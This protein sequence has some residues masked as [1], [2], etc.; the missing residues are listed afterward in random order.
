MATGTP[1]PSLTPAEREERLL[2][3]LKLLAHDI[4]PAEEDR[5]RRLTRRARIDSLDKYF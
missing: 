2:L 5:L 1:A 3:K 4:T